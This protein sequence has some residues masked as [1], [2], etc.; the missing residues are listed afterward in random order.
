MLFILAF[1]FFPLKAFDK[2]VTNAVP[3]AYEKPKVRLEAL[4]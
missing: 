3:E 2:D 4:L 1:F